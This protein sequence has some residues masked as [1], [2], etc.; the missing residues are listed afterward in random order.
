MKVKFMDT[1]ELIQLTGCVIYQDKIKLSAPGIKENLSGFM[2]YEDDGITLVHDCSEY[3]YRW[4][5]Y[6]EYENGIML[7]ES[8]TDR[9]RKPNPDADPPR[10]V[11]D[12]L[13][14]D[15]LTE[16]IADLMYEASMN[17][18]GM[19]REGGGF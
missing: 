2:L 12:P 1:D 8:E 13:S 10:E 18:L 9:E 3:K 17:S 7:T 5:I 6:T 4:N 16:A 19:M 15:E 14:N 11:V